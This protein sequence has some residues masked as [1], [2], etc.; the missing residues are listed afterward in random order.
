[1]LPDRRSSAS[2]AFLP[3][4]TR[5]GFAFFRSYEPP[6]RTPVQ[7][8]GRLVRP[9]RRCR[10]PRWTHR[11]SRPGRIRQVGPG[12]HLRK[13]GEV[14]FH[15]TLRRRAGRQLPRFRSPQRPAR[16]QA[17]SRL[18]RP[19]SLGSPRRA[20]TSF[21]AGAGV[22]LI[23]GHES[24]APQPRFAGR[25]AWFRRATPRQKASDRRRCCAVPWSMI[26]ATSCSLWRSVGMERAVGCEKLRF[27]L[28]PPPGPRGPLAGSC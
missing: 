26:A 28:L 2:S 25:V 6:A 3:P 5:R 11:L 13:G 19:K 7:L 14:V 16:T 17:P 24:M 20:H 21:G 23:G 8:Q 4:D 12:R 9:A 10:G 22:A 27:A 1:M 18:P 15:G